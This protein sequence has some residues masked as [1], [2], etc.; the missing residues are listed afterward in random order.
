MWNTKPRIA[1]RSGSPVLWALLVTLLV[2]A[3]CYN[4]KEEKLN[5]MMAESHV[6]K[7]PESK[8]A[9]AFN[10]ELLAGAR[11]STDPGDLL[12]GPGDLLQV[13]VFEAKELAAKVRVSSRGYVTLPLVGP[14]AVKGLSAREAELRIEKLYREKYIKDPHVSVFVE[15]HFSQRVTLVGE[16]KKPGT[17][18]YPRKMRLLDVLSL[19]GGLTEKAG[20]SAQIRRMGQ[21]PE[22]SNTIIVDLDRMLNKGQ[23]ELNIEINGGDIV[24]VPAAGNYFIS[25]AVL[26][27]GSYPIKD[28]LFL[29]EAVSTAGGFRSY[30]D[31]DNLVVIRHTRD[32]ERQVMELDLEDPAVQQM[33]VR[34]RDVI[35]AKASAWGKF[36][37]GF[38]INVG[39]P[40]VAGFGYR[41]PER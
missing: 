39:V 27:P 33:E 16:V 37:T 5:M 7:T 38:G 24:F 2:L 40:G 19:A 6:M 26:R 41:D 1:C 12:L 20:R 15:E 36:I 31:A 22:T 17:F 23:G 18:D 25:G 8:D 28:Q 11:I 3:G 9:E 32:G 34:D 4:P 29:L 35:I 13:E 10:R 30:A 21:S 14:V